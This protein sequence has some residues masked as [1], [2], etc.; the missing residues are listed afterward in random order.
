[1]KSNLLRGVLLAALTCC[2]PASA[3]AGD[4]KMSIENGRVTIIAD[5]V[6]V[7][8]ILQEWAR[9]GHSQILNLDKLS[10]PAVTLQLVDTPEK[11]A[12]DILLRSAS[13]YIAAPR[14]V[15][16]AGA[17]MY[18]RITIMATSRPPAAVAG[19]PPPPTFQRPPTPTDE[20]E[21]PITVAPNQSNPVVGSYPGMPPG[22]LPPGVQPQVVQ[23]NAAQPVTVPQPAVQ[24]QPGLPTAPQTSPR[25]GMLPAAPPTPGVPNPYQ[26]QVIRPGG[27]G[28]GSRIR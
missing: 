4:L 5:N 27:G 12:L 6:P 22:V 9:I 10:G 14:P 21:E 17:S 20:L 25:P 19:V 26:P 15:V 23:P 1:M 28:G 18:D 16:V 8:Q 2:V 24:S 7:R 3:M 11:D 13:G